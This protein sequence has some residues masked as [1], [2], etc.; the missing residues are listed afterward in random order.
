M[1]ADRRNR[2]VVFFTWP[3]GLFKYQDSFISQALQLPAIETPIAVKGYL[4]KV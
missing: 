3:E 4:R 1:I 2:W